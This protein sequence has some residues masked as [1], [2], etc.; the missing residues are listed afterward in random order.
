MEDLWAF[1][2][3]MVAR[4]V[5]EC[6]VPVISAVGHE[7]DTT[8]VDYVADL[9]APT[10]SAAAELAVFEYRALEETLADYKIRMRRSM[11]QKL[12]VQRLRLEKYQTRL[13]YLSPAGKMRDMRQRTAEYED[14]LRELFAE[15]LESRK[16]YLEKI[17]EKLP[18]LME[19]KIK[20]SRHQLAV[21]IE[22]MKGLSP[23]G[24]LNQGFSYVQKETGTAVKSVADVAQGDK[25]TVFVTD[26]HFEAAVTDI[27][28]EEHDGR[29]KEDI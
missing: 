24:K 25:V 15:K 3:E 29:N 1:N 20:E 10:P 8:I 9:R 4:A 13:G 19:Q 26:G 6:R 11:S 22:R 16:Q 23:L 2:E 28:K 5:F 18:F 21:R 27:R 17:E 12:H 7:T 14:R